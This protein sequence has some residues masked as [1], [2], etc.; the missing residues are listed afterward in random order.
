MWFNLTLVVI[1]SV[2]SRLKNWGST[3][4]I[5]FGGHCRSDQFGGHCRSD[6]FGGP[7]QSDQCGQSGTFSVSFD[8]T[9]EQRDFWNT[10]MNIGAFYFVMNDDELTNTQGYSVLEG[11]VCRWSAVPSAKSAEPGSSWRRTMDNQ[12]KLKSVPSRSESTV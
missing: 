9:V 10:V 11:G 12:R 6:R 5:E 1:S 7:L 8:W 2:T 3:N 4:I